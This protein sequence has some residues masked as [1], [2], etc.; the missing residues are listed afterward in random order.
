MK[1][2]I[3]NYCI[4]S[5]VFVC[6]CA[7]VFAAGFWRG[8]S[9]SRTDQ[10]DQKRAELYEDRSESAQNAVSELEGGL[11]DVAEQ[12]QGTGGKIKDGITD[13]GK[14]R[15][16]GGRIAGASED[17]AKTADGIEKRIQRIESTLSKAE[18]KNNSFNYSGD[19]TGGDSG[20]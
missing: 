17:I 9:H 4:V 6:I 2:E 14:L 7:V 12:L 13:V 3:K 11:S 1:N 8:C 10:R 20:N 15:E 5:V 16:V 19:N 18:E